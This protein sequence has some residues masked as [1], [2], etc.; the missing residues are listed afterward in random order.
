MEKSP[1][2]S[3]RH[4][5]GVEMI[6]A[7]ARWGIFRLADSLKMTGGGGLAQADDGWVDG[8]IPN[9]LSVS[10]ITYMSSRPS[11]R[12]ERSPYEFK[13]FGLFNPEV[14]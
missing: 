10:I 2:E 4:K 11:P 12:V 14:G 6:C 9:T 7:Q 8:G 1:H 5:T 13:G 3:E